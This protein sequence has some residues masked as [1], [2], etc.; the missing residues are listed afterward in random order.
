MKFSQPSRCVAPRSLSFRFN[1]P[2]AGLNV[3]E[4]MVIT[5]IIGVVLMMLMPVLQYTRETARRMDCF[6][7]IKQ[8][9]LACVE[10]QAT[11]HNFPTGGWPG[12]DFWIGDPDRGFGKRQP[13]GWTYNILPF[14]EYKS[15][16]DRGF[17]QTPLQKRATSAQVAQ[18]ALEVYYC[19]SRRLPLAYPVSQVKVWFPRNMDMVSSGARTDYASNGSMD[20]VTGIMYAGSLTTLKDI[21]DGLSHTYLLGEKNLQR[22]HYKDGKSIGDNLPV[23]ANS[24][25]DWERTGNTPPERDRRGY[26]NYSAFGSVIP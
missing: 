10:H 13:G 23:Y 16:H 5:T 7:H 11:L 6:N 1:R 19:P 15:L 24:F 26:E 12:P 14:M 8:L 2:K 21:R 25:C 17:Q 4:L 22:E 9:S 3:I 18:T 20:N